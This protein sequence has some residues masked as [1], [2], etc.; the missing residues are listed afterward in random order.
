MQRTCIKTAERIL[1]L[2]R[3][4]NEVKR[5]EETENLA[6]QRATWNGQNASQV[7]G[8]SRLNINYKKNFTIGV[9]VLD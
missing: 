6:R 1:E 5:I 7:F 2:V 9:Y 4:K 8:F 3:K